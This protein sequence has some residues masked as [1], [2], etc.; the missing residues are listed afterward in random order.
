MVADPV[1]KLPVPNRDCEAAPVKVPGEA[2]ENRP[3]EVGLANVRWDIAPPDMRALENPPPDARGAD[4]VPPEPRGPAMANEAGNQITAAKPKR[5]IF[6]FISV[7]VSATL[8]TPK[9][10]ELRNFTLTWRR[11]NRVI[12][13]SP[14]AV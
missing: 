2:V 14:E 12:A 11:T 6:A 7:W 5:N 4:A 10:P 8:D 9:W 13:G 3:T 1:P